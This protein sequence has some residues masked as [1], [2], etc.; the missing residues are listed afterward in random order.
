[1]NL[2]ADCSTTQGR[3]AS[4]DRHGSPHGDPRA[5][6]R[7]LSEDQRDD[8]PRRARRR[9]SSRPIV[10]KPISAKPGDED[11]G[12]DDQ[13]RHRQYVLRADAAKRGNLRLGGA[14]GGRGGRAKLL[15]VRLRGCGRGPADAVSA[16]RAAGTAARERWSRTIRHPRRSR[17]ARSGPTRT[18]HATSSS[19]TS[20]S[21]ADCGAPRR[22]GRQ[23]DQH[24]FAVDDEHVAER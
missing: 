14:G 6:E 4:G 23:V 21:S 5:D 12:G 10:S 16:P 7:G 11:V 18:Q 1:M 8:H 2:I 24:R 15:E 22:G 3:S 20:M 19:A 9:F 17:S 13:G